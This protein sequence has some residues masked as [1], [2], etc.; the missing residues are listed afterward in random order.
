MH[1]AK[2][3]NLHKIK[4]DRLATLDTF[5]TLTALQ[6]KHGFNTPEWLAIHE[7]KKLVLAQSMEFSRLIEQEE[8]KAG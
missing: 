2:H 5:D 6:V 3:M 4:T 8:A 1:Q 7:V